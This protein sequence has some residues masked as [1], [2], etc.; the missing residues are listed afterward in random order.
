MATPDAQDLTVAVKLL[1]RKRTTARATLTKHV[2][3]LLA[4]VDSSTPDEIEILRD[5]L[6]DALAE[7]QTLDDAVQSEISDD[8]EY[9]A[10]VAASQ[11]R[12]ETAKRAIHRATRVLR[13][14]SEAATV[15][16]LV[17]IPSPASPLQPLPVKTRLPTLIIEPFRGDISLWLRFWE[18]FSAS[19][20][21]NPSIST[22]DKHVFLR[23]YLRDEPQRLTSGIAITADSY[24][25]TKKILHLKY[26]DENQ[27]IQAHVDYLE[28]LPPA[29]DPTPQALSDLFIDC[30][31]RIQSLSAFSTPR[32][33]LRKSIKLYFPVAHRQIATRSHL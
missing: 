3:R 4:V 8:T 20:D 14:H 19:I 6:I 23:S 29:R 18:Q 2:N 33:R 12:H 7:L 16:A 21:S 27:I 28:N 26:G 9:E 10:D 31:S 1:H 24:E 17:P 15:P 32:S 25:D 5:M 13:G 30:N 22:I 11:D